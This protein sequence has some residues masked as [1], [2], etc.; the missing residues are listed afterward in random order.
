MFVK[1]SDLGVL[2][3][4]ETR[5]SGGIEVLAGIGDAI[6]KGKLF[7]HSTLSS[8]M[9]IR[10]VSENLVIENVD[11]TENLGSL[12]GILASA[13][14]SGYQ[15]PNLRHVRDVFFNQR[16]P[17]FQS[18]F[19]IGSW[20]FFCGTLF[21]LGEG[22]SARIFVPCV[23]VSRFGFKVSLEIFPNSSEVDETDLLV[24]TV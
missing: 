24:F 13:S 8:S 10:S 20:N 23:V 3:F 22:D 19:P 7:E 6:G 17:E 16:R 5:H 1:V 4:L 14:K 11:F 21:V 15:L 9:P 2:G 18:R 12:S